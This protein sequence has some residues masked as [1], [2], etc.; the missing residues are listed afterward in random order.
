[1]SH[2]RTSRSGHRKDES[3]SAKPTINS[4]LHKKAPSDIISMG[5]V[6]LSSPI[7]II[8]MEAERR[9]REAGSKQWIDKEFRSC[10]Y[11]YIFMYICLYVFEDFSRLR[12]LTEPQMVPYGSLVDNA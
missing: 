1:M 10:L 9:R 11:V 4:F 2:I 5:A 8:Q 7:W 12:A 6:H 3:F